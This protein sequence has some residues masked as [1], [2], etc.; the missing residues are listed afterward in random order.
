MSNPN[1][2]R[3]RALPG[4]LYLDSG[5][6]A[7]AKRVLDEVLAAPVG[8]YDAPEERRAKAH[9]RRAPAAEVASKLK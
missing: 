4:G 9:G 6:A 1:A 2:L 8:R 3:A 5:H 7:E